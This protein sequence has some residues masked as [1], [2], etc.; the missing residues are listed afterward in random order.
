MLEDNGV[1][2][3]EPFLGWQEIV[4]SEIVFELRLQATGTLFY[5]PIDN[6]WTSVDFTHKI[7]I[8]K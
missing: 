1:G 2:G 4:E 3:N 5:C 6:M 7:Q 8:Q